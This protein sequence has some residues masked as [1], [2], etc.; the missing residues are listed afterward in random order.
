[1]IERLLVFTEEMPFNVSKVRMPGAVRLASLTS[2]ASPT[3]TN[4]QLAELTTA[5][6]YRCLNILQIA[7]H[8][9]GEDFC[10]K[11]QKN[12]D[13]GLCLSQSVQNRAAHQTNIP[14]NSTKKTASDRR[15]L[16]GLPKQGRF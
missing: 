6:T 8:Q 16:F 4:D 14:I 1:M 7:V 12:L 9:Q 3:T 15:L 5:T 10:K 11:N 13:F 2:G